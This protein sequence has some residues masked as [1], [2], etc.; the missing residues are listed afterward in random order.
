MAS[1]TGGGAGK[2]ILSLVGRS[3]ANCSWHSTLRSVRLL[4]GCADFA[5]ALFAGLQLFSKLVNFGL[6]VL[7]VRATGAK[8]F[9]VSYTR[10]FVPIGVKL[11]HPLPV[12]SVLHC[13]P[14]LGFSAGFSS[15]TCCRRH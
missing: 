11:N 9:G 14:M 3:C 4:S 6:N 8:L 15:A 12:A 10:R 2:A 1:P 13:V 5:S 7:I